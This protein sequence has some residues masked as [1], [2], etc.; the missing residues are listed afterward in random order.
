MNAAIIPIPIGTRV[1]RPLEIADS[2]GAIKALVIS[3]DKI[4]TL[5]S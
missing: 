1:V 5:L 4:H 3:N 2:I